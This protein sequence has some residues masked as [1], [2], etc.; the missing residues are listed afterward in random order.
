MLGAAPKHS[1]YALLQWY[2][3]SLEHHVLQQPHLT[4]HEMYADY[5][6]DSLVLSCA[7]YS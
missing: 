4:K 3:I 5:R 2:M 6:H 7:V 1:D